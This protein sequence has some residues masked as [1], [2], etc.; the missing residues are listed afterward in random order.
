MPFSLDKGLTG[1]GW[2]IEYLIQNGS[3][4]G[5][6]VEICEEIDYRIMETDPKRITDFSL[7]TGFEGSYIICKEL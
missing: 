5:E 2:G 7:E 3:V 1:I 6:S 4:K